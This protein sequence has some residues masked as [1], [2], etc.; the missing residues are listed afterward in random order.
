[1]IAESVTLVSPAM[2]AIAGHFVDIRDCEWACQCRPPPGPPP[3]GSAEGPP[4]GDGLRGGRG[5]GKRGSDPGGGDGSDCPPRVNCG[6]RHDG[7]CGERH[8]GGTFAR[9]DS[10]VKPVQII[11]LSYISTDVAYREEW[12]LLTHVDASR[13]FINHR[14]VGLV[15]EHHLH[16]TT[17]I[18]DF[19]AICVDRYESFPRFTRLRESIVDGVIAE[20]EE[21]NR[22]PFIACFGS[23]GTIK[24]QAKKCVSM[25][26]KFG[27]R[28]PG[29]TG[30]ALIN[31]Y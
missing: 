9:A 22:T 23:R 16:H 6:E 27:I 25:L 7:G 10:A 28:N 26:T 15:S 21:Y 29:G 11:A 4:P 24:Q 3:P 17:N 30:S 2:A 5:V 14:L 13:R 19:G 18:G 12:E 31:P 20:S 1:M 8:K